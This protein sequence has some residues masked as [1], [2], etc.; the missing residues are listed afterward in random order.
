MI[1]DR[2]R[3]CIPRVNDDF[4]DIENSGLWEKV[5][6]RARLAYFTVEKLKKACD[7]SMQQ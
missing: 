1:N 5:D 7:T 3:A 6:S 4:S 2:L